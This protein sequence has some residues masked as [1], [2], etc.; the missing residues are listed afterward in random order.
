L[1]I[2]SGLGEQANDRIV[3]RRQK[4]RGMQWGARS[5]DALAALRTLRLNGG[6]EEYWQGR[7]LLP[8]TAA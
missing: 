7:S 6:W 5:S 4:Q 8:L 1:D 3:A 2:G